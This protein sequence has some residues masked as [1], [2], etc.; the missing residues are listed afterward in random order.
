MVS[1][2][3]STDVAKAARTVAGKQVK[4]LLQTYHTPGTLIR[5]AKEMFGV[6]L[7][8]PKQAFR[9]DYFQ[10]VDAMGKDLKKILAQRYQ[11]EAA[12]AAVK[13]VAK[14][15]TKTAAQ[16]ALSRARAAVKQSFGGNITPEALIKEAKEKFGITLSRPRGAFNMSLPQQVASMRRTLTKQLAQQYEKQVLGSTV[17]VTV[18]TGAE[19]VVNAGKKAIKKGA[20][21]VAKN[22]AKRVAK[23]SAAKVANAAA[24]A[25]TEVTVKVDTTKAAAAATTGKSGFFGAIK[26]FFTNGVGRY[27]WNPIRNNPKTAA[28]IAVVAGIAIACIGVSKSKNKTLQQ[29]PN[30]VPNQQYGVSPY[31]VTPNPYQNRYV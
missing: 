17:E 7:V 1:I 22:G 30:Q 25:A 13:Q 31:G 6:D 8:R 10:Q 18:K 14:K 26:N 3:G 5:D 11:E 19:A 9:M 4:D 15:G 21:R 23:K 2:N 28:A 20:K 27:V 16:S 12:K 29:I 24:K